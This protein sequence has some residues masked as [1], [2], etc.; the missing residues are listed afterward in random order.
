MGSGASGGLGF[1]QSESEFGTVQTPGLFGQFDPGGNIAFGLGTSLIDRLT[2]PTSAFSEFGTGFGPQSTAETNL[3]NSLMDLTNART[4]A[5][6]L[7]PASSTTLA[8]NIAPTLTNL[9]QQN[10]QNLLQERGQTL[11]GL[12]QLAGL[13]APESTVVEEGRSDIGLQL[14]FGGGQ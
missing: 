5:A 4:A 1:G 10:V 13:A 12:L 14:G 8:R 3:L 9:R 11:G 6:G 2:G 7:G